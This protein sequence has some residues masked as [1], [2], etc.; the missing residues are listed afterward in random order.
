MD[1]QLNEELDIFAK[2]TA[3]ELSETEM[4]KVGGGDCEPVYHG[5]GY[6]TYPGCDL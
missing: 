1:K 5:N 4:V 2:A 3:V 6:W